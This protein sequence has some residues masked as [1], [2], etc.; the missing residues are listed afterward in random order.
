MSS[1]DGNGGLPQFMILSN[2]PD[3]FWA[4]FSTGARVF[5]GWSFTW[6]WAIMRTDNL[7][8][9][10]YIQQL[11]ICK[12]GR[13][14][15]CLFSLPLENLTCRSL[16]FPTKFMDII[17]AAA[18]IPSIAP[19][20]CFRAFQMLTFWKEGKVAWQEVTPDRHLS[21]NSQV[22]W[23]ASAQGASLPSSFLEGLNEDEKNCCL[24]LLLFLKP[25]RPLFSSKGTIVL[26]HPLCVLGAKTNAQMA[27][28]KWDGGRP[29]SKRWPSGGYRRLKACVDVWTCYSS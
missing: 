16:Y 5:C 24:L 23:H 6:S 13:G 2:L 1:E 7:W 11:S 27:S 8:C 18:E 12:P 22:R 17:S 14:T 4:G 21:C 19:G 9:L 25:Q 3:V 15:I 28:Q 20:N 26:I 29:V 10:P